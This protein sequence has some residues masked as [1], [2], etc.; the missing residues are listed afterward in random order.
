M[1]TRSFGHIFVNEGQ[2]AN[3]VF[4]YVEHIQYIQCFA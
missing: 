4:A 1:N 3:D 2:S